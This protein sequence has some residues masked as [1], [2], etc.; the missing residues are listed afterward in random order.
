MI[1]NVF[2]G[3]AQ[4]TAAKVYFGVMV[5][6]GLAAWQSGAFDTPHPGGTASP[7]S[8][9]T[10]A[11]PATPQETPLRLPAPPA[12]HLSAPPKR[13]LKSR[14][15]TSDHVFR[16][17]ARGGGLLVLTLMLMVGTFLAFRASQALHTASVRFMN[18]ELSACSETAF[19]SSGS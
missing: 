7:A 16:G 5:I 2:V 9:A 10:P 15:A 17:V 1:V 12:P 19:S 4:V 3:P 6:V 14:S 11:T 8:P 18:R 13:S